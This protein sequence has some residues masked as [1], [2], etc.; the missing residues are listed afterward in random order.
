VPLFL[1][2]NVSESPDALHQME[3]LRRRLTGLN[4]PFV[5]HPETE[6]RGHKMPLAPAV[7]EPLYR[8][9]QGQLRVASIHNPS[10]PASP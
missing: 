9:L 3:V 6:P 1:T 7:L 8:Y 10:A 5:Y 2:I 4:S